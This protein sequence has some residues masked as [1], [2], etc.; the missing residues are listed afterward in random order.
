MKESKQR[1]VE[2]LNVPCLKQRISFR[3]SSAAAVR[4][5]RAA[6]RRWFGYSR[7]FA[8]SGVFTQKGVFTLSS[9]LPL[10]MLS[11][12]SQ[13]ASFVGTWLVGAP[14]GVVIAPRA[15]ILMATVSECERVVI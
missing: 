3:R 11:G 14:R 12:S 2:D 13:R 10:W 9:D 4:R 5:S 1:I 8:S 6:R 7:R 15:A